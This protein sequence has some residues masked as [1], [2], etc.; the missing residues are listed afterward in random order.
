MNNNDPY[1]VKLK[2]NERKTV[3]IESNIDVSNMENHIE[4][5]SST[6]VNIII[7]SG[8]KIRKL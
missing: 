5:G 3:K 8:E 4:Q 6:G 1:E 2:G 7:K